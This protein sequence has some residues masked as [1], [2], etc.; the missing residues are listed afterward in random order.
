MEFENTI[1]TTQY[2]ANR[3][4]ELFHSF[5]PWKKITNLN[6][7]ESLCVDPIRLMH[8]TL[9]QN[10][11]VNVTLTGGRL[12]A[13]DKV[14]ELLD[15]DL[16]DFINAVKGYKVSEGCKACS[17]SSKIIKQGQ[18]VLSITTFRKYQEYLIF[19][20][21]R[22]SINETEVDKKKQEF[23]IFAETA[24]QVECYKFWNNLCDVL[25]SLPAK[26]YCGD[27]TP[28]QT[29]LKNRLMYSY[30]SGK[31]SVDEQ[32]LLNEIISLKN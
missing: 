7:F 23:Q 31:L 10:S 17:K 6:D 30:Q 21:G 16:D 15:I 12:P 2:E 14:A 25:N 32:S 28:F 11:G 9:Q 13:P 8:E 1:E 27:L 26:N 5:Q 20:N 4:V 29:L 3:L 22:F 24:E 19:D 18:G